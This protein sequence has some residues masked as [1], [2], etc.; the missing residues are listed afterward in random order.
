[1]SI[2][3]MKEPNVMTC[4]SQAVVVVLGQLESAKSVEASFPYVFLL[5]VRG[6]LV[7]SSSES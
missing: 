5:L 2:Q 3:T 1:M 4:L 6:F 7:L